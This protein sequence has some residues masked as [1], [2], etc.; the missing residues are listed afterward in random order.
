META[1]RYKLF[2]TTHR[3]DIGMFVLRFA[4]SFVFVAHSAAQII[5]VLAIPNM[6]TAD[7]FTFA[8]ALIELVSSIMLLS[9]FLV[10]ATCY[11]LV[12]ILVYYIYF[13]PEELGLFYLSGTNAFVFLTIAANIATALVGPGKI[14][15][16]KRYGYVAHSL[17]EH[18]VDPE[19]ELMGT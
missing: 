11:S 10:A 19:T 17:R 4:L 9:G 3:R 18:G 14:V 7:Y 12:L 1:G 2:I 13:A 15:L 16:N 5:G 8:L 6:T